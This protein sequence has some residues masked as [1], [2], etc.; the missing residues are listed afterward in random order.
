MSCSQFFENPA[1]AHKT[2]VWSAANQCKTRRFGQKMAPSSN[3]R[4]LG[5]ELTLSC[6]SN[7]K[8]TENTEDY[9]A[10]QSVKN[11][12]EQRYADAKCRVLKAFGGKVSFRL[13]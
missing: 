7:E 9:A 11:W 2:Y 10:L 4:S 5:E 8:N 3:L 13:A 6:L 1:W 12:N